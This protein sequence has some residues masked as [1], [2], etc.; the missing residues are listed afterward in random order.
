MYLVLFVTILEGIHI[1]KTYRYKGHSLLANYNLS[2]QN[3]TLLDRLWANRV[4]F[5][6]VRWNEKLPPRIFYWHCFVSQ[7]YPVWQ[8]SPPQHYCV[9]HRQRRFCLSVCGCFLFTVICRP[10]LV[11]FQT[12]LHLRCREQTAVFFK[13]IHLDVW[14]R[15]VMKEK[16]TFFSF[17]NFMALIVK[18]VTVL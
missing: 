8:Y 10:S 5:R 4:K 7:P 16:S 2:P 18:T 3:P 1:S 9:A 13:D 6:Y 14:G 15:L 17:H 11:L 12:K